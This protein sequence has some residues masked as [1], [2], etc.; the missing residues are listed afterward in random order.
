MNEFL[1]FEDGPSV[2]MTLQFASFYDASDQTSLS[3]IW[4]GIHPPQDDIVSRHIGLAI[5][6]DS[7]PY[8]QS[9]FDGPDLDAD[10]DLV[11]DPFDN[12][13]TI[14]NPEQLDTDADGIGDVCDNLCIG[15]ITTLTQI[16]PDKTQVGWNIELVGT[17]FGPSVQ[18][19][20]GSGT[21]AP[22]TP[23]NYYGHW[24]VRVPNHPSLTPG[25][26]AV[27][28]I[29]LEGCRSQEPV[30][31]TIK[32]PAPPA[33]CGLTG[34]EPFVLLGALGLFRARRRIVG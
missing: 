25:P 12:C 9:I 32:V 15:E 1:V 17:G 28:V 24:L 16:T 6:N 11:D 26:H 21:V 8:A 5:A 34:I 30:T 33:S 3:R 29:N 13:P 18:V 22:A 23:E 10:G 19:Q 2:D 27:S 14:A 7:F 4:G 31:M 20:F